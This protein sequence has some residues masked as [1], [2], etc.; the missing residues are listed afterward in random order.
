MSVFLGLGYLTKDDTPPPHSVHF[1]VSFMISFFSNS[2]VI[3]HLLSSFNLATSDPFTHYEYIP[4]LT[5][6][7]PPES[8]SVT[9]LSISIKSSSIDIFYSEV[10]P[11]KSVYESK[12][13]GGSLAWTGFECMQSKACHV[14]WVNI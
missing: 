9:S 7:E 3:L 12:G 13:G 4:L 2:W 6:S 1:P 14:L 10:F 5:T 8:H 11:G